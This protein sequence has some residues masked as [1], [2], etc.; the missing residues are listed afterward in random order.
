[1][2]FQKEA[3]AFGQG[4]AHFLKEHEQIPDD[5][6]L[7][8]VNHFMLSLC[9]D[10]TSRQGLSKAFNVVSTRS[11]YTLNSQEIY[12]LVKKFTFTIESTHR[13]I[14]SSD[15]FT[16]DEITRFFDEINKTGEAISA[17]E[18]S[19]MANVGSSPLFQID[20]VPGSTKN[21]R[22]NSSK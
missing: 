13:G 1:M 6:D 18:F 15:I 21:T 12:N 20:D 3:I 14:G 19:E 7:L 5:G 8:D 11:E 2:S 16:L 10:E 4:G 9:L 17:A 22:P